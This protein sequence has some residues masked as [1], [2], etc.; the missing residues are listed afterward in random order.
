MKIT[1]GRAIEKTQ[2]KRSEYW[3]KK[4]AYLIELL[5]YQ[6]DAKTLQEIFDTRDNSVKLLEQF[7]SKHT[8]ER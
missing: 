4:R 2:E 6:Y 7:K 3:K 1:E 8:F 5:Q